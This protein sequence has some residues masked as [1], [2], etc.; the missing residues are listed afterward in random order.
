[1]LPRAGGRG[2]F[3]DDDDWE[4]RDDG[5]DRQPP[6]ETDQ[7][8]H[9]SEQPP[10]ATDQS[11]DVT[12]ADDGYVRWFLNTNDERVAITRD[13]VSSVA[14][15]AVIGLLLFTVSGVW[16]PLVAVE[17]GSMEPNMERGDLI[18]V[19]DDDRFVGDEP[20]CRRP[21]ERPRRPTQ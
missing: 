9:G 12:I 13:I 14:I 3:D 20:G 15:V 21:R 6:V 11:N 8:G 16:P 4:D 19:V 7:D 18:F 5:A 1:M 10:A 17:S 2:R